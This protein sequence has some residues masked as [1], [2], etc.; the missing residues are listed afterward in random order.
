MSVVVR[1]FC[2][3]YGVLLTILL[4]VPDPWA[5]LGMKRYAGSAPTLG[6]HGSLFCGLAVLVLASRWPLSSRCTLVILGGYAVLVEALQSLVPERSVEPRDF[7]E[8]FLGL[9]V[10]TGVYWGVRRCLRRLRA[11]R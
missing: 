7:L 4:L 8:N 10:G 3:G 1:L 9:L 5:L 11:A 6:V 2:V